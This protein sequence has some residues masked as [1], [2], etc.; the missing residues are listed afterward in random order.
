MYAKNKIMEDDTIIKIYK[1]R[2][3]KY[4]ECSYGAF[5]RNWSNYGWVIIK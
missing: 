5:L 1:K 2:L 3:N 4:W